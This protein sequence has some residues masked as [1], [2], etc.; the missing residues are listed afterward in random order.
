M[1]KQPISTGV[2][3]IIE[4][5]GYVFYRVACDCSEPDHDITLE[6]EV[7]PQDYPIFSLNIYSNLYVDTFWGNKNIFSRAWKRIKI[8]LKVL[9]S[10][11]VETGSNFL[12]M[13]DENIDA[14]INA[15]QE[16]KE[17]LEKYRESWEKEN[18]SK[19]K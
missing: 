4:G 19:D 17:K 12:L 16:G 2:M 18:V 8:A 6:L 3:K 15:L 11:Y 7:D 1:D 9:W 13:K 10:G 14:F 5:P